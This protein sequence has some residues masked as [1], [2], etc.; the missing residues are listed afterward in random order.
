MIVA[1]RQICTMAHG[2]RRRPGRYTG[3]RM[4]EKVT[5]V[6]ASV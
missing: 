4:N 1:P 5:I 6:S 3:T 2:D